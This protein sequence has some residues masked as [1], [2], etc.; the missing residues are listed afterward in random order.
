[1]STP[2]PITTK[3]DT[4]TLTHQ[5]EPVIQNSAA[6]GNEMPHQN[7]A[8]NQST[9][10]LRL[11]ELRV[12]ALPVGCAAASPVVV[13]TRPPESNAPGPR[14]DSARQNTHKAPTPTPVNT[15]ANGR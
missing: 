10:W 14:P 4:K 15:S 11:A 1:M 2:I 8:K 3:T 5:G 9:R 7:S 6:M 13:R 12:T